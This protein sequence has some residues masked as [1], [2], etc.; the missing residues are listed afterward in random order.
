ML[1]STL[2][3]KI[4]IGSLAFLFVVLA[5][6]GTMHFF[7]SRESTET[8]N[9]KTEEVAKAEPIIADKK[10]EKEPV[11]KNEDQAAIE[12]TQGSDGLLYT[13]II[14]L[15]LSLTVSIYL[16]IYILKW[17]LRVSDTQVSVVPE[18]L[19]TSLSSQSQA[20]AQNT[21]YLSEYIKRISHDREKTDVG[22][23]EL[24][25]AFSIFQDSLNKKDQEIERYK[26]GYD[27]AVYKKFLGKFTK[28]YVDLKREADAPENVQSVKILSDMLELMEDALLECNVAIK[29]PSLMDN[30]D[31][32]RE[33]ISGNKKVQ[34]TN[35]PD[36]HGKIAEVVT[37]AFMLKTQAGDEVL[38]EA[39]I[40]VYSYENSEAA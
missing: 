13:A 8:E 40:T 32:Y 18:V 33:I 5:T 36:L 24:Q 6:F 11:A 7:K 39:T 10:A 38:R 2:K 21:S 3:Q 19:L 34:K 27:S 29:F 31:E 15:A 22:I 17:R 37:P 9:Q 14:L 35:Q 1:K 12:T 28:F 16:T 23:L 20:L 30:A 4:F 26:K 25:K